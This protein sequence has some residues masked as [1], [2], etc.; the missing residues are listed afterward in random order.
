MLLALYIAEGEGYRLQVSEVCFESNCPETTALRWLVKLEEQSL[1]RRR[2]NPLDARSS[3]VEIE[4]EAI[5]RLTRY[6]LNLG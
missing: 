4:A 6:F 1:I 5:D 3:F 2:Q